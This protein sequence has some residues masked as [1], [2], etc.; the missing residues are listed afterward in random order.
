MGQRGPALLSDS[1]RRKA[2]G[3][4]GVRYHLRG[5]IDEFAKR[6]LSKME[7]RLLLKVGKNH[8]NGVRS[9]WDFKEA[10]GVMAFYSKDNQ[11]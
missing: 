7:T 8:G 10:F 1:E 5:I 3:D 4:I 9:F 6:L 2:K 11:C